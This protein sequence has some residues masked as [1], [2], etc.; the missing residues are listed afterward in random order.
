MGEIMNC[1]SLKSKL[2]GLLRSVSIFDLR[3]INVNKDP[4]L[5]S[6]IKS[7]ISTRFTDG[8]YGPNEQRYDHSEYVLNY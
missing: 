8:K 2:V 7:T 5:Y 4:G 3:T 1:N 6:C